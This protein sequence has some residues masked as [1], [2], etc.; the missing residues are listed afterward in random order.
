MVNKDLL[1]EDIQYINGMDEESKRYLYG[2]CDYWAKENFET[3]LEMVAIMEQNNHENGIIHCYL[4]NKD[5][6]C[7]YDVRG[8]FGCDAEILR[9]TGFDY[10]TTI[11]EEFVFENIND[12]KKFLKWVEFEQ[13]RDLFE[14]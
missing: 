7:C 4:R 10:Y 13:V 9:Y 5:S 3:G 1:A 8:E 6:D 12:F 11:V 14:R 2:E